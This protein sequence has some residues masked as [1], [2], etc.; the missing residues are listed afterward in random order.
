M[1]ILRLIVQ[2]NSTTGT[3]RS[4]SGVNV[5]IYLLPCP[6]DL[7]KSLYTHTPSTTPHYK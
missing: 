7:L 5:N 4:A 3:K 1:V 2:I 6:I